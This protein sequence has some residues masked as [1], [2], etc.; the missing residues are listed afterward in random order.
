MKKFLCVL[1][2]ISILF[3]ID[4]KAEKLFAWGRNSYYQ[5]GDGTITNRTSPVQIGSE[6]NWS[7]ISC[8]NNHNLVIKSNGTLWAWGRNDIGQL[9]NGTGTGRTSPGQIGIESSWS[10][11]ACGAHFSLG[12]TSSINNVEDSRAEIFNFNA[13]PNPFFDEVNIEFDLPTSNKVSLKVYDLSGSEVST[14]FEG[15]LN[16]G[17]HTYTFEGA[18]FAS[19]EYSV[20][21]TIGKERFVRKVIK[22]K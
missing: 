5:L 9:G 2:V 10:K 19:G 17:T 6:A 3:N 12:I 18:N 1:F 15:S 11:V 14:L 20:I 16:E 7:Q 13:S 22:V 21:L 4:L 8:A